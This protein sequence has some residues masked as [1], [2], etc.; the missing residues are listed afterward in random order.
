MP[1]PTPEP[2][3]VLVA[4]A[5]AR[6]PR[7]VRI[8]DALV[9]GAAA[10]AA[11]RLKADRATADEIAQRL[12]ERLWIGRTGA[13]PALH[14]FNGGAPLSAW[15]KIIAYREGVDLLRRQQPAADDA[16]IEHLVGTAEP[17]LAMVRASYVNAFKRAFS[18]AFATLSLHDRDLLRRHH[19]D[20]VTLEG[21]A[22]LFG[23]H[24]ATIARWL[25]RARQQVL[26]ETRLALRDELPEGANLD[27]VF[28]MIASQLDA[29]W[30]RLL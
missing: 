11:R 2:D 24:R 1:K 16:L 9:R 15:L 29:S 28:E 7:A 21:L 12:S 27:D 4:R 25:A 17:Q 3:L 18:T 14:E 19:L 8:V 23:A 26:E 30:S 10:S 5:L 20:G 6:E 22:G 13:P